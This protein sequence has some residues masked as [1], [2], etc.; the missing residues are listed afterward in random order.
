MTSQFDL[1]LNLMRNSVFLTQFSNLGIPDPP[2][3]AFEF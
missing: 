2:P 3:G 1:T